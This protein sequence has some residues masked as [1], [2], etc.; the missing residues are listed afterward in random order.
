[1]PCV[2]NKSPRAILLWAFSIL[3]ICCE[4]VFAQNQTPAEPSE[5]VLW[6]RALAAVGKGDAQAALADLERLVS[7]HPANV[8]YRFELAATLYKLGLDGRARYHLDLI[9]SSELQPGARYAVA[10]LNDKI[11]ARRK[12]NGYFS[13]ALIPESNVSRQT[14]SETIIIQGLPFQLQQRGEPGVS[15]KVNTGLSYDKRLSPQLNARFRADL[16]AKLNKEKAF[17]DIALT[18]RAGL[19][20]SKNSRSAVE[21]G[22]LLGA[23]WI[24][25]KP[26]SD[27]IGAYMNVAHRVSPK[28]RLNFTLQLVNTQHKDQS[29]DHNIAL[30]QVSYTH[31]IS[32]NAQLRFGAFY[33][34]TNSA[35]LTAGGAAKGLTFGSDYAFRGGLIGSLDLSVSRDNR[36]GFNIALFTEARQDEKYKIELKLHHRDV[37]IMDFAPQLIVGFERNKSNNS[38]VDFANRYLTIGL[39]KKF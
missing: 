19:H 10:Q 31:G 32:A 7:L 38:I 23:R 17:R 36:E 1:M 25:D 14:D 26:Y 3:I 21:G 34:I 39:T 2:R 33:Q 5:T 12:W 4:P 30:T 22:L 35:D 20:F 6:E 15:V 18:G 11:S 13:F 37:R 8:H 29:P 9:A 27:T 24:G 28:G 16:S